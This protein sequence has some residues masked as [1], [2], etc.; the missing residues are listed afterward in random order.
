MKFN[1]VEEFTKEEDLKLVNKKDLFG[2]KLYF[3]SKKDNI[4]KLK[5]RIPKAVLSIPNAEDRKIDRICFAPS[6][7][8][9][10]LAIGFEGDY[11]VYTPKNNMVD[12]RWHKCT[13]KD[14]YFS[15]WTDEYW[16]LDEV[17]LVKIAKINYIKLLPMKNDARVGREIIDYTIKEVYDIP[18][19]ET[20]NILEDLA[21]CYNLKYSDA[22]INPIG[23]NLLFS[24]EEDCKKFYNVA[25]KVLS[26]MALE[27]FDKQIIYYDFNY[28]GHILE[29]TGEENYEDN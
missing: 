4:K 22:F 14:A 13:P 5:P 17:E 28:L 2:L 3:I 18:D 11:Y 25:K 20:Y 8:Q 1:L 23:S 24:T 26:D 29:K 19:E 7:E 27:D 9:C 10:L 12:L 21:K 16:C 6:I 15:F